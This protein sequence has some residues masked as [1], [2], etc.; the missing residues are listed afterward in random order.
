MLPVR[1]RTRWQQLKW[2]MPER[3]QRTPL[4]WDADSRPTRWGWLAWALASG[5]L[6][7]FAWRWR[8]GE[9][10]SAIGWA[11][12][13]PVLALWLLWPLALGA[14]ALWHWLRARPYAAWHGSY[15]EFDGRQIRVLFDGDSLWVVA[16][17]VF[18]A[19]R[20]TGRARD[21]KR[22]RQIAGRDGLVRLPGSRLLAFTER[23]LMAW[24]ERRTDRVAADFNRWFATQVTAPHR[25]RAGR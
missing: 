16:S 20:L 19:L 18:D 4:S 5:L 22:V 14:V 24:M 9:G 21:L 25:R 10:D 2:R 12:A 13:A 6:L 1:M 23:G 15:L 7:T 11:L 3:L 8:P 17:D